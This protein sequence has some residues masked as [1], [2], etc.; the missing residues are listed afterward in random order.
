MDVENPDELLHHFHEGNTEKIL[1]KLS[2]EQVEITEHLYNNWI[3]LLEAESLVAQNDPVN[4]VQEVVLVPEVL[5]EFAPLFLARDEALSFLESHFI[6]CSKCEGSFFTGF[7]ISP[8]LPYHPT[9]EP[10]LEEWQNGEKRIH[11]PVNCPECGQHHEAEI[12]PAIPPH[13][14]K[15]W[16]TDIGIAKVF[17]EPLKEKI[18]SSR[19]FEPK[20]IEE[21]VMDEEIP[22][23]FG[24]GE[25]VKFHIPLIIQDYS[26]GK[27]AID[28]V[29]SIGA[30]E[31]EGEVP[32]N[33]KGEDL[34]DVVEQFNV[35]CER[36]EIKEKILIVLGTI[37]K[38]LRTDLVEFKRWFYNQVTREDSKY[39]G[40]ELHAISYPEEL[41]LILNQR[42]YGQAGPEDESSG[43]P[44]LY[45]LNA[46]EMEMSGIDFGSEDIDHNPSFSPSSHGPI[47]EY[48]IREL[49]QSRGYRIHS[50]D[51]LDHSKVDLLCQRTEGDSEHFQLIQCKYSSI[52]VKEAAKVKEQ[53]EEI[54]SQICDYWGLL[55]ECRVDYVLA[56]GSLNDDVREELNELGFDLISKSELAEN[57]DDIDPNIREQLGI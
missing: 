50:S 13:A 47:F 51:V 55:K 36:R 19:R 6:T 16:W 33:W 28:I 32:V 23:M 48:A 8:T 3:R 31:N 9:T 30:D 44:R 57:R 5:T 54:E 43:P 37:P 7:Y 24:F 39:R 53:F 46:W 45:D 34:H 10:E 1:D 22:D 17:Q 26:I 35:A 27:V 49:Q 20:N 25:E 56:V 2:S 52:D 38:S 42:L 14:W 4:F 40:F 29:R 41:D 15:L 21:N 12:Q 11:L 18:R